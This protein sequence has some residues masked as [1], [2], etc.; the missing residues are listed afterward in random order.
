MGG[1]WFGSVEGSFLRELVELARAG[2]NHGKGYVG[3][4]LLEFCRKIEKTFRFSSWM[5][6]SLCRGRWTAGLG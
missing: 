1:T 6:A 3:M 2:R 4:V 5:L